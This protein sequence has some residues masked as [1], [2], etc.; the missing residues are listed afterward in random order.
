MTTYRVT[1][2]TGTSRDVT[3]ASFVA[4][5]AGPLTVRDE[6]G[7]AVAVFATGSWASIETIETDAFTAAT[8]AASQGGNP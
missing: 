7:L 5:T 4:E 1:Y 2:I 8:Q 3:G 6:T